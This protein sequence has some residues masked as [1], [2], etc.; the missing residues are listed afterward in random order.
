[1]EL[2]VP[3]RRPVVNKLAATKTLTVECVEPFFGYCTGTSQM[4]CQHPLDTRKHGLNYPMILQ[5]MSYTYERDGAPLFNKGFRSD[6]YTD[7]VVTF[8]GDPEFTSIS[9]KHPKKCSPLRGE[10]RP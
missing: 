3:V 5:D 2:F 9:E 6:D 1:M 7:L 10:K 8:Q 4:N